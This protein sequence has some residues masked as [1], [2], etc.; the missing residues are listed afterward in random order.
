MKTFKFT[1]YDSNNKEVGKGTIVAKDEYA[2]QEKFEQMQ[3][4]GR[5]ADAVR[6]EIE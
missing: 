1:A 6:C 3:S 5:Y 2:A 4:N